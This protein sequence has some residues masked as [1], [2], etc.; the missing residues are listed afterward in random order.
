MTERFGLDLRLGFRWLLLAQ[1]SQIASSI[2]LGGMGTAVLTFKVCT[3]KP[4]F[5][6][7]FEC[8]QRGV[9]SARTAWA[10]A[11]H[12]LGYTAAVAPAA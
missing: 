6:H 3:T 9:S 5:R 8:I 4:A 2:G 1:L 7:R 11:R 10:V 12:R